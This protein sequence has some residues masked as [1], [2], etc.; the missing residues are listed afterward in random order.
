MGYSLFLSE[1]FATLGD[2]D[3]AAEIAI[4]CFEEI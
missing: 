4:T 3:R 1:I 2:S